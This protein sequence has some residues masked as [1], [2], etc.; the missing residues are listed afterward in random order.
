VAAHFKTK[1]MITEQDIE[2]NLESR[3]TEDP[4][5]IY[6]VPVKPK[7]VKQQI[8]TEL[9]IEYCKTDIDLFAAL[10]KATNKTPNGMLMTLHRNCAP[11]LYT[12]VVLGLIERY[13]GL[14][15]HLSLCN[16]ISNI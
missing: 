8:L 5:P 10:C 4:A 11:I 6:I 14:E 12:T 1:T 9:A 16:P 3:Q 15:Q 13:T 2:H 7:K